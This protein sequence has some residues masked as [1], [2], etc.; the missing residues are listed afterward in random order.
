LYHLQRTDF[1]SIALCE[2]RLLWLAAVRQMYIRSTERVNHPRQKNKLGEDSA[3]HYAPMED[4][5]HIKKSI[6]HILI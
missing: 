1:P 2:L 3:P 4:Y 6:T 5:K